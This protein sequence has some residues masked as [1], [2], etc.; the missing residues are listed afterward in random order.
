M[1]VDVK[2]YLGVAEDTGRHTGTI[3]RDSL[4]YT[5]FLYTVLPDLWYNYANYQLAQK[6]WLR[7]LFIS[8]LADDC[9]WINHS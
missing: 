5:W 7:S 2:G 8:S 9:Q 1:I 6:Q 3:L 4:P